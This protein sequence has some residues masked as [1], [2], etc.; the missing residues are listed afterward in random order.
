MTPYLYAHPNPNA[1]VRS[2]GIRF[3]GYPSRRATPNVLV[4]HTTE[5]AFDAIGDDTG[6][7]NVARYQSTTA[8]PSSYHRI[9]DRDSTVVCLPDEAVAFGVANMNSRTLHLSL[10]M[11]A[12]DWSDPDK[13]SA[14][15]PVY[16]RAVAEARALVRAHQL[17]V[18]LRSREQVLAGLS[19]ITGHGILDPARRSD[20][21]RD[22]PW[23]AFL[24]DVADVETPAPQTPS[25]ALPTPPKVSDDVDRLPVLRR[26]STGQ[27]VRNLQGLLLAAGRRIVIDGD[28]GP[29]TESVLKEWQAA[30]K[31]IGGADGI[32]GPNSWG[33]FLGLR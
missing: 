4:I 25:P 14:L 26:G 29:G 20:P 7:E 2:N 13:R 30:A 15:Q 9:V 18:A 31:V 27:A 23:A 10:A 3:W 11:R 8:R 1:P 12:A 33:R 32:C 5:S 22:F 16:T 21:G 6:A 19:G 17:P 24:A 28:F